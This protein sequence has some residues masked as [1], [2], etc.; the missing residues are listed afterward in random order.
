MCSMLIAPRSSPWMELE[1]AYAC[2]HIDTQH[3][4]IHVHFV[5]GF[6]L[7]VCICI[8]K[9]VFIPKPPSPILSLKGAASFFDFYNFN[10]LY[11]QWDNTLSQP[12]LPPLL[13]GTKLPLC[14]SP[15]PQKMPCTSSMSLVVMFSC[16]LCSWSYRECLNSF[17]GTI[18][19]Y[20][21]HGSYQS[22]VC[23]TTTVKLSCC[24]FAVGS[25]L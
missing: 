4:S 1:N 24:F 17:I 5:S 13:Q 14:T 18:P 7:S 19:I 23:L 12:C 16:F 8:Y 25:I 6:P 9:H 2:S 11:W 20:P 15:L 22:D 3:I 10:P 21:F